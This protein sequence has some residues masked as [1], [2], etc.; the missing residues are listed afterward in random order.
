LCNIVG[1]LN[2]SEI[3][4]SEGKKAKAF[5]EKELT[6]ANLIVETRKKELYSRYLCYLYYSKE[7]SDF[8]DIIRHGKLLN[9]RGRTTD[10][11]VAPSQI[12]ACGIPAPGSSVIL[13]SA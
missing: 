12:P 13:T 7:Y 1:G 8:T 6:D 9:D 4:M 5:I 11:P 10:C 3:E 2:A